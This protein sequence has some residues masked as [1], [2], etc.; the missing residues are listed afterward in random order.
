MLVYQ[1]TKPDIQEPGTFVSTVGAPG[2]AVPRSPWM[3][4]M[5]MALGGEGEE[6]GAWVAVRLRLG[7]ITG[8]RV[9]ELIFFG[10]LACEVSYIT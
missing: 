4:S 8:F 10:G 2:E 1:G 3:Q 7:L 9:Q 5:G 6:F